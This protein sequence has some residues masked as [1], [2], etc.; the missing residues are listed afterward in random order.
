MVVGGLVLTFQ[1]DGATPLVI[2]R[3]IEI[4]ESNITGIGEILIKLTAKVII[5]RHTN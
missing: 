4:Y 5:V 2:I 3:I 1:F